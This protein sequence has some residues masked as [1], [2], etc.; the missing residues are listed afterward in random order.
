MISFFFK[1]LVV[2]NVCAEARSDIVLALGL[3]ATLWQTYLDIPFTNDLPVLTSCVLCLPRVI[4]AKLHE[5]SDILLNPHF[6][7]DFVNAL[8]HYA[9]QRQHWSANGS[10]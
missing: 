6:L 1:N 9:S 8:T 2:A 7:K 5:L 3:C 10:V 4:A